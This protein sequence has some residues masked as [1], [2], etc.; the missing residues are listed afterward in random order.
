MSDITKSIRHPGITDPALQDRLD[1]ISDW[2]QAKA[3]C[4]AVA[5]G[6][7]LTVAHWD[8]IH[9]LRQHY[10]NHGPIAS[11]RKWTETLDEEFHAQG[12]RKY[13]YRLFPRGPVAQGCRLA[14]LPTPHDVEEPSFGSVQ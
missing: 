7:E 3:T 6:L 14:G 1:D 12:G 5:E 13:L 10:L 2:D 9:F 4:L 8:V 11:A